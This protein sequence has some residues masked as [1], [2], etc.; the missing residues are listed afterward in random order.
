[1]RFRRR[2]GNQGCR[3]LCRATIR[4]G[5]G[6]RIGVTETELALQVLTIHVSRTFSARLS[7]QTRHPGTIASVGYEPS[8][9]LGAS[10]SQRTEY[11]AHQETRCPGMPW[12]PDSSWEGRYMPALLRR[13]EDD[14]C[15]GAA[16]ARRMRA[17]C[18]D[19]SG[20]AIG[21]RP[22]CLACLLRISGDHSRLLG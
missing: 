18:C 20:L 17:S 19:R 5:V 21:C 7:V 3:P 9:P 6:N 1:M 2:R 12:T 4:C 15:N 8:P 16:D 22:R 10:L 13:P 11:S 14:P